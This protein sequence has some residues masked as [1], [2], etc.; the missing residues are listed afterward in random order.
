MANRVYETMT[1]AFACG[2]RVRVWRASADMKMGPEYEIFVKLSETIW[3]DENDI[4]E[5]I[6]KF[7]GVSAYEIVDAHGNGVCVYP[8]WQ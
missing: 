3:K 7:E 4:A 6:E 2:F 8:D 5:A 1:Q